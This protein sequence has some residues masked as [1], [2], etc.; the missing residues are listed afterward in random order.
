MTFR[1]MADWLSKLR[2][3][4]ERYPVLVEGKRDVRTLNRLGIRNV[5]PLSGRRYADVVDLLETRAPGA[6][7]LYDLDPHGERISRR[8]KELLRSQGFVVLEEFREYLR[9]KGIIHIEDLSEVGDGKDK[10]T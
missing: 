3:V 6:V 1:S 7:L 5:I 9:G 10:D 2:E 4:S 8:M